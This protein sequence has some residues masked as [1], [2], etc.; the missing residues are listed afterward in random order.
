LRARQDDNSCVGELGANR[1]NRVDAA[2]FRHL[3]IHERDIRA[4]V[5]KLFERLA[6]VRRFPNHLYVRLRVDQGS[7]ALAKER[8][9]VYG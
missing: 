6:S 8:M 1:T 5:S 2:H 3:Q 9:V 4:M 7:N